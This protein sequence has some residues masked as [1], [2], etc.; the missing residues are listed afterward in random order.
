MKIDLRKEEVQYVLSVLAEQPYKR[1]ARLIAL[2][3][4]ALKN[5]EEA[6]NEHID[7]QD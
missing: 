6:K 4:E 5:D 2:L 3:A 7:K 1:V